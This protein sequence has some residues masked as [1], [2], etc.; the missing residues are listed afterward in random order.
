M[1]LRTYKFKQNTARASNEVMGLLQSYGYRVI[2]VNPG[3]HNL[4]ESVHGE[5]VYASLA[6]IP[7]TIDMVDIFRC[8]FSLHF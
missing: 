3:L 8:V 5:K 1:H 7:E 6:D 4:G 2:P